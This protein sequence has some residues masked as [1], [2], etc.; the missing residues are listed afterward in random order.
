MLF[1]G[2]PPV[3]NLQSRIFSPESSVPN[4]QS[5]MLQSLMLQFARAFQ[6][7]SDR[8]GNLARTRSIRTCKPS[9]MNEFGSHEGREGVASG[10]E[11]LLSSH[12]VAR[13]LIFEVESTETNP[14]PETGP[15]RV[16]TYPMPTCFTSWR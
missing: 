7:L 5:P 11:S 14:Q 10:S 8:G 3:P 16:P 2:I 9:N 1:E 6:N 12:S 13:A 15:F 4:L